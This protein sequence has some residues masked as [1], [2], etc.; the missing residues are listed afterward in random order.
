MKNTT[1]HPKIRAFCL[2][3]NVLFA[4]FLK[5]KIVAK[6]QWAIARLKKVENN[7]KKMY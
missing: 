6:S 5:K 3:A 4:K 1:D 2:K 7:F